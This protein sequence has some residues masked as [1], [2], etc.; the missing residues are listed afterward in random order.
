M[1]ASGSHWQARWRRFR[2]TS[3]RRQCQIVVNRFERKQGTARIWSGPLRIDIIPTYRCNLRCVGCVHYK[4]DGPKDLDLDLFGRILDE[5]AATTI[6]YK[7]CS[8]GEPFMNP[9]VPE[10]M[11][12]AAKR[13]VGFMLVTNGTLVTPELADHIVANTRTD[14]LTFSVDGAKAKTCEGLRRGLKFEKLLGGI[15]AVIE[16]K[17][18]YGKTRPVIQ[19]NFVAMRDNSPELPDL[20]RLAGKI[21]IDDVNVNYLTIEGETDNNNSLFDHPAE[22]KEIFSAARAAAAESGVVLHL[23]PDL[24]DTSWRDRCFFPWD[25]MIIDTDG[26]ARMCYFSWEENIG[27]IVT[28]GGVKK[29]WNNAILQKVRETIGSDRPFYHYCADCGRQVGFSR[30][31]AN[32]GKNK[33]NAQRF[34]FDWQRDDAPPRATGN[35]LKN[36]GIS[37]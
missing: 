3:V 6:Q 24:D 11:A 30:M 18:R 25:T 37:D 17:R 12:M 2:S 21:G 32:M 5:T 16:A 23:P 20:I 19:A 28:D 10:M 26:T 34:T 9:N 31:A 7:F 33:E 1:A 8:I 15:S 4:S 22:Q 13:G 27:N 14:V 29:V 36:P 35:K